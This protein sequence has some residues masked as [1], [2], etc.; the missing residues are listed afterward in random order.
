MMTTSGIAGILSLKLLLSRLPG[1]T[2]CDPE[3][4]QN[5]PH[6]EPERLLTNVD[7]VVAEFLP[8][9][10]VARRVDL[11][12]ARESRRH[13]ASPIESGHLF[14]AFDSAVALHFNFTRAERPRTHKAH[15]AAEDVP[16]LWQFVES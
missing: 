11:C 13:G 9:R 15:V 12:N 6:V 8:A 7:P 1:A 10:H 5:Q 4:Q 16:E 2:K 3:R 14:Q